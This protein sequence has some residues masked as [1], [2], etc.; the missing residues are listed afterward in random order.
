MRAF[1]GT[2]RTGPGASVR[3]CSVEPALRAKER[4]AQKADPIFMDQC[5]AQLIRVVPP[6]YP[7]PCFMGTEMSR[8]FVLRV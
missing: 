6:G 7:V 1:A 8:R 5:D 2:Y 4:T 3:K